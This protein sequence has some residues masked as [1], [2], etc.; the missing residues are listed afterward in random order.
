MSHEILDAAIAALDLTYS[1]TFIPQSASRNAGGKYPSINWRVTLAKKGARPLSTD[2]M[3]GIGHAPGYETWGRGTTERAEREQDAAERG[4]YTPG[5]VR[6]SYCRKKIPPP[7][8]RDVLNLL[9]QDASALESGCFEAWA[10]DFGYD[11]DSREAE[12]TYRACVDT[13]LALVA[14]IG[15]PALANLRELYQDY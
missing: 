3:Q 15:W 9:V 12:R 2:Y 5:R 14:L 10:A 7:K 4:E 11:T 6:A 13:G 1:A 8:L